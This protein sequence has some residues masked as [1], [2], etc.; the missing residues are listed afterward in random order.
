MPF[1]ASGG[2]GGGGGGGGAGAPPSA[3]PVT[4]Q[5]APDQILTL[6]ARYEA[7]RDTVQ[8]FVDLEGYNLAGSALSEDDVSKDAA[9]VFEKNAVTAID[10]ATQFLV[11]LSLNID[12]LNQAATTYRLVEDTN[13]SDMQQDR[14]F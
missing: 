1:T 7:V 4:M 2:G 5:V 3:G 9:K 13:R 11:E 12:Q 6:K 10:V 14:G 8:A